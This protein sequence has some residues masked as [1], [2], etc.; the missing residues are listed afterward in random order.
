MA[1]L[2][3]IGE[4]VI[5][6]LPG[7]EP[8]S[9]IRNAGGAPANVAISAARNG[10][11]SGM[12]T[13]VG[14][15]D[16]GVFLQDTLRR[17]GVEILNPE[18]EKKA[19]TTLAFVSL[20][21]SGERSF[22]F[23]RKPGA[24]MFLCKEEITD[25][26]LEKASVIHAGS[27]SLSAECSKEAAVDALSRA[28]GMGKLVSF[29]IN[30]RNVA[31]NDDKDACAGEVKKLLHLVDF[32]KV[33][34]EEVDMLGGEGQIPA[35]MEEYGIAVVMLTLGGDGCRCYYRGGC[36]E[37][38]GYAVE[39]GRVVDT[40]G[41]GDAFWGGFLSRLLILGVSK[42]EDL[43]EAILKDASDYGNI[44]GSICVQAKGAIA[45]LPDRKTIEDFRE[46]Q[47]KS[48]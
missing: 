22:T 47:G 13:K 19:L 39:A 38:P 24:D 26:E 40:T 43:T 6:F 25:E 30:Y 45:S 20:N 27:F 4:M 14:D 9:Y 15:D 36:F 37:D 28:H 44:S 42:T 17:E 12:Y 18:R 3:C 21:E 33:S 34:D 1:D 10:I 29:D 7:K 32:L 23:G 5:D 11:S 48:C 16:F 8:G 2:I 35:V 46:K 41:A 31:W